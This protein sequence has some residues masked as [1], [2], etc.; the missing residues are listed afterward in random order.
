[1]GYRNEFGIIVIYNLKF[2]GLIFFKKKACFVFSLFILFL[3]FGDWIFVLGI[4]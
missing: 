2:H 3:V 1:M 4:T